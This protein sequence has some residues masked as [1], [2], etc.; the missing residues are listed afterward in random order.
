MRGVLSSQVEFGGVPQRET[1]ETATDSPSRA[2]R[3]NFL[4]RRPFEELFGALERSRRGLQ[5]ILY[6]L[7][8]WSRFESLNSGC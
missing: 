6:E 4:V 7:E 2:S 5:G 1:T 8:I 3:R